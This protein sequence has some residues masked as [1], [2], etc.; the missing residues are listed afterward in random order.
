MGRLRMDGLRCGLVA[1]EPVASLIRACL[2]RYGLQVTGIED[3]N[4]DIALIDVDS[5]N[6]DAPAVP[7]G[8]PV[9]RMT[10]RPEVLECTCGR[11][12][13]CLCRITLPFSPP[14]LVIRVRAALA[15]ARHEPLAARP[16]ATDRV[17]LDLCS[18]SGCSTCEAADTHGPATLVV[19][20]ERSPDG[21]LEAHAL[22]RIIGYPNV[23]FVAADAAAL[24]FGDGSFDE[25]SG[26]EQL[27][28][29]VRSP[30]ALERAQAEAR[31]VLRG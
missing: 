25:V 24:P 31:S 5:L 14:G 30:E 1:E 20:V 29:W 22:A 12:D 6:A 18:G 19:G 3:G 17:V 8:I 26:E 21:A 23:A 4:L 16:P 15:A 11:D 13:V 10:T 2:A 28:N 9:I 27:G 7:D